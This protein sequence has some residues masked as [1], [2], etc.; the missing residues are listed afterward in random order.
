M[1]VS[2]FVLEVSLNNF[3]LLTMYYLLAVI[4]FPMFSVIHV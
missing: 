3:I 1:V 2:A 4:G